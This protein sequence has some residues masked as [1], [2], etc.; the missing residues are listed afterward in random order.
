MVAAT[1]T[2][3]GRSSLSH[4]AHLDAIVPMRCKQ[5]A[6]RYLVHESCGRLVQRLHDSS[7][8]LQINK[9]QCRK[10]HHEHSHR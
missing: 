3:A 1:G 4:D 10:R 7:E 9:F 2:L 6:P 5:S 8:T